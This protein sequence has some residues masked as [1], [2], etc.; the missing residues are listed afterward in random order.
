MQCAG[1]QLLRDAANHQAAR[2]QRAL[3]RIDPAPA[4]TVRP[5]FTTRRGL[6]GA[7][8]VIARR[9]RSP[10][11]LPA[12]VDDV[13]IVD[14]PL[15]PDEVEVS[16]PRYLLGRTLARYG[17]GKERVMADVDEVFSAESEERRVGKEC[18]SRWS[19]YH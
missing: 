11:T 2:R 5:V 3:N 19:P 10:G 7:F 15:R 13:A 8:G 16:P 9:S 12:G 14:G 4:A 6:A 17:R 18:R 1:L